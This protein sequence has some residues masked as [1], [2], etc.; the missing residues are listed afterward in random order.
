MVKSTIVYFARNTKQLE[1]E[2]LSLSH[3]KYVTLYEIAKT[4][5]AEYVNI[6]DF[7]GVKI[8]EP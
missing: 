6:K 4:Y 5:I 2:L 1:A 3:S 8:N 7:E